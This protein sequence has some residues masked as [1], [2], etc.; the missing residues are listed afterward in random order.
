MSFWRQQV[1]SFNPS[2]LCPSQV[3]RSLSTFSV[4]GSHASPLATLGS[5]EEQK[6]SEHEWQR[7][8]LYCTA[9][10]LLT[11][12]VFFCSLSGWLLVVVWIQLRW[13]EG[14]KDGAQKHSFSRTSR[15]WQINGTE[16]SCKSCWNGYETAV[17]LSVTAGIRGS[18]TCLPGWEPKA[19]T[20]FNGRS[21]KLICAKW[22]RQLF[23]IPFIH[24]P[25]NEQSS[26][27][28]GDGYMGIWWLASTSVAAM[29]RWNHRACHKAHLGNQ[30]IACARFQ[31][32]IICPWVDTL[33][34]I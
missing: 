27:F 24:D 26:H 10:L 11:L 16:N 4:R 18:P 25:L 32:P 3:S 30:W 14:S 34:K 7:Q 28:S 9:D 21:Q 20:M 12:V 31:A 19:T 33:R 15:D 8:S 5:A 23:L 13:S 2:V 1:L 6:T 17:Q 22:R 29:D